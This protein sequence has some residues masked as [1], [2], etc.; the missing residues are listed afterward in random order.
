[1]Q[2]K[3]STMNELEFRQ[4]LFNNDVPKKVQSDIVSR[5]KRLERINGYFDLD[6]EYKKD[7]CSF[8]FSLFKN[9]GINDNMKKIGENDLPIGKYQLSTYKYALTQYVKY[10]QDKN[11]R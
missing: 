4:W 10:L 7:K 5:L 9:K 2:L 1:M 3:E 6:A 8:L 11:G